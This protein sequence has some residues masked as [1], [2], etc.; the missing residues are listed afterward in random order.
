MRRLSDLLR[1]VKTR[2]S[3]N[4]S[5]RNGARVQGIVIH[6]TE[7]SYASAVGWF[8][9]NASDVSAHYVV[10]DQS[11]PGELWT[12]VTRM[13][14]EGEKA[15]TARSANPVTINYE[16]AG[17]AR[18]TRADWLGAYRVQLETAAALVADDLIERPYIPLRRGWPGVLGHGDLDGAG[19]PNDHTDP[20]EGFPW[21]VFL[22]RVRFYRD[23]PE[24][25]RPDPKPRPAKQYPCLPPGLSRI[26]P[27]AFKLAAWHLSGREGP[28]PHGAPTNVTRDW[29]WYWEWLRCR[30]F[31][32][33]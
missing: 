23:N 3:P 15:W 11:R 4:R 16:L 13:V 10:S 12:E 28:R 26:P 27:A 14:P 8:M 20:G 9:N 17:F 5:S 31:G 24:G 32:S 7:G 22:A 21:D 18:R 33:R 25:L 1:Q 30:Y 2:L 29:P 6:T 19:F